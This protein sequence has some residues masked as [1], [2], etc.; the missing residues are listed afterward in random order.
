MHP[1]FPLG[2]PSSRPVQVSDTGKP[3]EPYPVAKSQPKKKGAGTSAAAAGPRETDGDG[4]AE[5]AQGRSHSNSLDAAGA[6]SD[7]EGTATKTVEGAGRAGTSGGA[8]EAPLE[9]YDSEEGQSVYLSMPFFVFGVA[10]VFSHL[11]CP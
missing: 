8:L 11:L 6:N 4:G 7:L 3:H 9:N 1:K 5:K 10:E 2:P